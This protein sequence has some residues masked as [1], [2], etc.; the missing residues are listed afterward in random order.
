MKLQVKKS[1]T[2]ADLASEIKRLSGPM[3]IKQSLLV[4]NGYT[5]VPVKKQ[6]VIDESWKWK[7]NPDQAWDAYQANTD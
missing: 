1:N 4:L 5:L 3:T 6:T 7:N 2:I